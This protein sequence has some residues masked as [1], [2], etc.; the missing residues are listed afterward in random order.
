MFYTK[1]KEHKSYKTVYK[2]FHKTI[3]KCKK[4]SNKYKALKRII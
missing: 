3:P 1:K 2:R 4:K